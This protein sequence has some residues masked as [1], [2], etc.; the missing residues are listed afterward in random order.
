MWESKKVKSKFFKIFP[1]SSCDVWDEGKILIYPRQNIGRATSILHVRRFA[2]AW[3][4]LD[5]TRVSR[6]IR[7]D[8][9]LLKSVPIKGS[10]RKWRKLRAK[11]HPQGW[12]GTGSERCCHQRGLFSGSSHKRPGSRTRKGG[13]R[14]VAHKQTGAAFRAT[15]QIK[16]TPR[17]AARYNQLIRDNNLI[18][19]SVGPRSNKV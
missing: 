15:Q 3:L 10:A 7:Y 9:S 16:P 6:V 11:G 2:I 5:D 1:W 8:R 18:R 12:S 19:A 17:T 14:G 13:T 4:L